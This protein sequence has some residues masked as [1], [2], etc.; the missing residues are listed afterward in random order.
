MLYK[1][2]YFSSHKFAFS[3]L[4]FSQFYEHFRQLREKYAFKL[5]IKYIMLISTLSPIWWCTYIWLFLK[6]TTSPTPLHPL[7]STELFKIFFS[8][9]TLSTAFLQKACGPGKNLIILKSNSQKQSN[10]HTA[11]THWNAFIKKINIPDP[12]NIVA[13]T[14]KFKLKQFLLQMQSEGDKNNWEICNI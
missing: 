1:M 13:P 11:N 10:D 9:L 6:K 7:H 5:K 12:H 2:I 3:N 14:L 8:L 4:R